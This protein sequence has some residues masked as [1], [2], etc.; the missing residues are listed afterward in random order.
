MTVD[1]FRNVYLISRI[2]TYH[3][4][5]KNCNSNDSLLFLMYLNFG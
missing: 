5:I 2:F 3:F 4:A 1:V